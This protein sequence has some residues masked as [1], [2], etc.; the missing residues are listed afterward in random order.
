MTRQPLLPCPKCMNRLV[1]RGLV[2]PGGKVVV[3]VFWGSWCG[4]CMAAV[5]HERQLVERFKGRPFV[6][7]GV[8]SDEDREK[9][10]RVVAIELAIRGM[11]GTVR[12]L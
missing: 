4:P 12:F 7:V 5:P 3:L 10:L 8:N 2:Y 9:A 6:V 1:E 11:I